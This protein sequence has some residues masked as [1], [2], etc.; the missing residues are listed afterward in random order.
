MSHV[1]LVEET[2]QN[3][4]ADLQLSVLSDTERADVE[5]NGIPDYRRLT[6][7]VFCPISGIVSEG[8]GS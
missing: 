2:L 4:R 7:H 3:D 8:G 1:R 6:P 5:I